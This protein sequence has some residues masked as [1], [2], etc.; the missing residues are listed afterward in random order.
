[1]SELQALEEL[2]GELA[3]AARIEDPV[4]AARAERVAKRLAEGRFH[5]MVV[6]EFKRGKSTLVN[7]LLGVEVLPTGVLPLTAVLT[8]IVHGVEGATVVGSDGGRFEISLDAL[9]DYVTEASNPGNERGVERVEVRVPAPVLGSGVVLVDT[10]GLGSIHLHN[11]EAGRASLLEADGAIVVLSADEPLSEEERALLENLAER[12]ARTFLVV[13]RADHLE[14]AELEEVRRFITAKVTDALGTAPELYCVSARAGLT[15]H[16]QR[17]DALSA[18]CDWQRFVA[19]FDRFVASELVGA[20][21]SAAR[22][23]LGRIGEELRD[24]VLLRRGALDLDV[25][26]LSARVVQF[27]SAAEVQRTAFAEERVI[28]EHDVDELMRAVGGSLAAFAR[29]EPQRWQGRL[30][31]QAA[32]LS[33]GRLEEGLRAVVEEAVRES[34]ETFRAREAEGVERAWCELAA[35]FRSRTQERVDAVR[36]AASDL[37]AIELAAMVVPVVG[38][39][40]E[41]FFYLFLHVGSTSEGLDRVARRL[42]PAGVVR[43]RLLARANEQLVREFDKHAGRARWDLTQRL[44][45]V[46]RRFETAMSAELERTVDAIVA[47]ASRADGLRA[48]TL[49]ELDRRAGSDEQALRVAGLAARSVP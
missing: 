16:K 2:A 43:R 45:G 9:A 33:V 39:E 7:A 46:R 13:N 3:A 20:R 19:A 38:E 36:K 47:A 17:D 37:F 22:A 41:R 32:T 49:D 34:F 11:T 29:D 42:L 48:A 10:P 18:T 4:L 6:G 40:R 35:R 5:V 15:A 25:E 1:M 8:E 24:A 12:R 28:L 23:E 30:A 27:R 44:D 26:T 21:L 14:S 31:E